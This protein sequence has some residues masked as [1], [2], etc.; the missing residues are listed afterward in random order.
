M[1]LIRFE[2]KFISLRQRIN[3]IRGDVYLLA[4]NFKGSMYSSLHEFQIL[5]AFNVKY[6]PSSIP[7]VIQV[8][9]NCP[10]LAWVKCNTDRASR[11]CL[12]FSACGGIF[13]GHGGNYLGDFSESLGLA[14][15]FQVEI[16]S[17][18]CVIECASNEDI[19]NFW[20]ECDC[21]LTI[22][23]FSNPSLVSWRLQNRWTNCLNII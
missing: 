17:V 7:K 15:A 14:I 2:D 3:L 5:K 22:Q 11:G 21:S 16:I 1:N 20:L 9:C 12:G 13:R 23:V 4:N 8:N 19:I 10:S 18:T 6:P